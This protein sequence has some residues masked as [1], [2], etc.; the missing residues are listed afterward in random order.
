MQGDEDPGPN[1]DARSF[2]FPRL[3][4]SEEGTLPLRRGWIANRIALAVAIGVVL[5]SG[6]LGFAY[7]EDMSFFEAFYLLVISVTTVGYGDV[8]PVTEGGRVLALAIVPVGLLLVFGLGV[9]YVTDRLDDLVL[10]GGV[11]R[12]E[13]KIGQ[14]KNHFIVCGCG[15]LGREIAT[16][17]EKM[18]C[19]VVIIDRD[20]ER[21]VEAGAD[22][23]L[24]GDAL[25]EEVLERA[26][27]HRAR[28]ILTTFSQDTLNVYLVLEAREVAP[29]I[30]VIST[31]SDREATRR[32]YLAGA[33]RVV[34]PQ[35]LGADILAKSAHS[36]SVYQLMTDIVSGTTPED[37]IGQILINPG[38]PLEGRRLRDF[39]KMDVDV[40]VM[41]I[42]SDDSTQL[43][44]DGGA[45]LKAGSVLV[46][47]GKRED[48]EKLDQLSLPS[49]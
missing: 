5:F 36:P 45:E 13:R 38:S 33:S 26:G 4:A 28:A 16:N 34:S 21:L 27:I 3:R 31:A 43:S 30:E 23:Y 48:L 17:L 46:V 15:R 1:I 39:A 24:V 12:L 47:L 25:R 7:L 22:L 14:L 29:E 10:R 41:L 6:T 42:R 20:R 18:G 40:R 35:L 32:L 44:P 11:G 37:N 49:K 8:H 9:S 2:H 19:P